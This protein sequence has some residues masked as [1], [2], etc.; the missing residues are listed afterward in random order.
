MKPLRVTSMDG[1]VN[2]GSDDISF[3]WIR[4]MYRGNRSE[5]GLQTNSRISEKR[6]ERMCVK[7]AEA[8]DEFASNDASMDAQSTQEGH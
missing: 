5:I 7:I 6:A 3:S 2:I 4:E 8:V 1:M